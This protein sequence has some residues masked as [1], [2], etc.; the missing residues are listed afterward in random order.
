MIELL[1]SGKLGAAALDVFDREPQV[2][3]ELLGLDNVVL[4]PHQGS[5]THPTRAAM[6]RLVLDNVANQIV[7]GN[8]SIVGVML[9]SNLAG[10][11]QSITADLS[12]LRYGVSITD[13]CLDWESTVGALRA[14]R[15]K[16]RD[17]LPGRKNLA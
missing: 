16:L 2:P 14:M 11:N 7:E 15:E 12:Q 5:A 6:G 17:V 13:G 1:A 3:S 4:H 10:G 8:R 9:E